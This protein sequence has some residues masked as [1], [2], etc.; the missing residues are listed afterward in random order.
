MS[1]FQSAQSCTS[2]SNQPSSEQFVLPPLGKPPTFVEAAPEHVYLTGL[3][4]VLQPFQAISGEFSDTPCSPCIPL[5][6]ESDLG[7][8]EGEDSAIAADLVARPQDHISLDHQQ[9]VNY[10]IPPVEPYTYCMQLS[11]HDY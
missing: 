1:A 3:P 6:G 4:S 10:V 5:P 2:G 8:N 11:P 7:L 9:S